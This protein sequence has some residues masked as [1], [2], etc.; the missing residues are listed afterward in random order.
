MIYI[1][2]TVVDLSGESLH[3]S[4]ASEGQGQNNLAANVDN[5]KLSQIDRRV[6]AGGLANQNGDD[7]DM[8]A[9]DHRKLVLDSED[10]SGDV[11]DMH[12]LKNKL[13]LDSAELTRTLRMCDEAVDQSSTLKLPQN[14]RMAGGSSE[15]PH[16]AGGSSENPQNPRMAAGSDESWNRMAKDSADLSGS[17]SGRTTSDAPDVTGEQGSCLSAGNGT[18]YAGGF[19][20][21][22]AE[23]MQ[24]NDMMEQ[25]G[26]T[27]GDDTVGWTSDSMEITRKRS[28]KRPQFMQELFASRGASCGDSAKVAPGETD[29]VQQRMYTESVDL[30]GPAVTAEV[31]AAASQAKCT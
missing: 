22:G 12:F 9:Y 11:G 3:Y 21:N 4:Y 16:L 1:N 15:N 2:C 5:Y 23:S 27:S 20:E 24:L 7:S 8:L 10:L 17:S 26:V 29:G 28:K 19:S 25:L 14:P 13:E 30:Y 6:N 18:S 31:T